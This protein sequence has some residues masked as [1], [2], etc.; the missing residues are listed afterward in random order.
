MLGNND[1]SDLCLL[2]PFDG[3]IVDTPMQWILLLMMVISWVI[4][5]YLIDDWRNKKNKKET[6]VMRHLEEMARRMGFILAL[7][8]VAFI[9]GIIFKNYM[10][11]EGMYLPPAP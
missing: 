5:Y 8:I 6:I 7:I 4:L 1:D 3:R 2:N 10:V 11:N 9:I